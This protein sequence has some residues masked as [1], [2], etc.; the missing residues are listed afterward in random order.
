M[1]SFV[2]AIDVLF[3]VRCCLLSIVFVFV[4]AVAV[5]VALALFIIKL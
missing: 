1:L 5:V 2:L 4:V 3:C